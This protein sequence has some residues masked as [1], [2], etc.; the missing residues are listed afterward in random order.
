MKMIPFW[1]RYGL[2]CLPLSGSE[3]HIALK[4]I[5]TAS[6]TL[7]RIAVGLYAQSNSNK[8]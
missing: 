2:L 5:L 3:T 1:P 4:Q 8:W 6:L 7:C